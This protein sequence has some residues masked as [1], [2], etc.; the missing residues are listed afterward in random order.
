[1]IPSPVCETCGTLGSWFNEVPEIWEPADSIAG[2][3][4]AKAY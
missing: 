2:F 4:G 3:F 1:M